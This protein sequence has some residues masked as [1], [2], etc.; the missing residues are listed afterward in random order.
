MNYRSLRLSANEKIEFFSNMHTML[1]AG[2]PILNGVESLLEDSKGNIHKVFAVIR[3]DLLAGRRLH[4]SLAKFPESFD[5]VIVNL[6]KAAEEAGTL[7]TT[8]ADIKKNTQAEMEFSDKVRSALTYPAFVFV[9]FTVV[10]G[11]MLFVVMPKISQVF[12]R[13]K[14]TI[15][16]PTRILIA[17][18]NFI[19]SH[20]L[21]VV[22]GLVMVIVLLAFLFKKK[23]RF[24]LNILF[25]LPIVS[26]LYKKVDIVRFSRSMGLLLSSGIPIVNALELSVEVVN[27]RDLRNL[28]EGSKKMVYAG[29]QFSEGL[30]A[31]KG[32]MP[33]IVV[34]LI[35][36]GESSGSLDKAM[37]DVTEYMDYEVSKNLK[38]LTTLLEPIM[39]VVVGGMVGGMMMSIISPMYNM[40]GQVSN[41]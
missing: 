27:R 35:E 25:H 38:V 19:T 30:R 31:K 14:V 41:R 21:E 10:M 4:T 34:K 39:L 20:T 1:K 8:L 17:T 26:G 40:I 9:L 2:I 32:V 23:R 29:R 16:L 5:K 37:A 18:S 36:L 13:L 15:P 11:I 3:E 33:T 12:S 6:I 7:E 22:A 28:L 24:L